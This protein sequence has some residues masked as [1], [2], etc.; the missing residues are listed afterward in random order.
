MS[1]AKATYTVDTDDC[2]TLAT[3]AGRYCK[4]SGDDAR[5]T[6]LFA[7]LSNVDTRH[8][9]GAL[10]IG[11]VDYATSIGTDPVAC[12]LELIEDDPHA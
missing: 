3:I 2:P 9:I 4:R 1:E 12:M 6:A 11:L 8:K 5:I 10:M 7:G